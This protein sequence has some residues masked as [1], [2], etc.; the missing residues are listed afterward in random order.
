MQAEVEHLLHAAGEEDRH[1]QAREQRLG[2]ARDRRGLAARVVAHDGE[3][4]AGP[5]DAHEVA[6]AQR[7]GGA[8]EPG[9][10]AVPH[11]QHAV[12]A[13]AGQV[14]GELAAPGRGGAELLV[15]PG[16]VMHMVF[17]GQLL[18]AGELAVEAAERRALVA[19]DHRRRAESAATVGAVLVERQA[20][21]ALHAREQDAAVLEDVLVVEGDVAASRSRRPAPVAPAAVAARPVAG[22]LLRAGALLSASRGSPSSCPARSSRFVWESTLP[23]AVHGTQRIARPNPSVCRSMLVL[24]QVEGN[25]HP[26]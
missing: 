4:A 7:V 25:L 21:E 19:G 20:D 17:P 2:G 12:V 10:L 15:Q 18:V 11:R 13:R 9:R 26:V 14:R 16:Y 8:V 6:V 23:I 22:G 3:R 1:V 24:S 5:G